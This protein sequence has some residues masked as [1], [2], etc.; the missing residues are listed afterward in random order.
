MYSIISELIKQKVLEN[1]KSA[2]GDSFR[3]IAETDTKN[4]EQQTFCN[5]NDN[6]DHQSNQDDSGTDIINPQPCTVDEQDVTPTTF[7]DKR[8]STRNNFKC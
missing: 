8:N 5:V 3:I 6:R 2:Y 1:K 4:S 7:T